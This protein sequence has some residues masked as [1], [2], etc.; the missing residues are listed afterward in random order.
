MGKLLR[1]YRNEYTAEFGDSLEDNTKYIIRASAYITL[2]YLN[3]NKI[4]PEHVEFDDFMNKTKQKDADLYRVVK[5][6]IGRM[7]RF[8][9]Y[10]SEVKKSLTPIIRTDMGEIELTDDIISVIRLALTSLD[11]NSLPLPDSEKSRYEDILSNLLN[12]F[13]KGEA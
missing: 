3:D 11:I 4:T 10:N 9:S 6:E 12:L 5:N 2:K 7:K 13:S 8:S 1:K